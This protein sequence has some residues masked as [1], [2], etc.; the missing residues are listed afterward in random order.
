LLLLLGTIALL[1]KNRLSN[2]RSNT[3]AP[4]TQGAPHPTPAITAIVKEFNDHAIVAIGESH[5][6]EEAGDFYRDLVRSRL[7]TNRV[8]TVVVEFG[9]S[10]YQPLL[11]GYLSGG[12]VA[13]A[14]L[15]RVWQDTTQ[16]GSWDAPMYAAFFATV[17]KT[18]AKLA[19]S[20]RLRVL[21]GDPP[22]DWARVHTK[23]QWQALARKR[24]IFFA[25]VIEHEVLA[26]GKRALVIA[27]LAHVTHGGGGV[28]DL[29]EAR[30]PNTM[31]VAAV[32]DGFPSE[33]LERRLASWPVPS[34]A[35]LRDTWIGRLPLGG[36]RA[37]DS[38]DGLLYLGSPAS[39]HLSVTLP[40]VYRNDRYWLALHVRYEIVQG[41]PFSETQ[42]FATYLSPPYPSRFDPR[43]VRNAQRFTECMRTS[44]VE[45]FPYPEAQFDA[46]GFFGKA[47]H[48]AQKDPDFKTAQRVCARRIFKLPPPGGS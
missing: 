45:K 20:R 2:H 28:S 27:G 25:N 42:L 1:T 40:S 46:F 13:P 7:F 22:I 12:N 30:H 44:G 8:H 23:S 33:T 37:Q 6:L 4:A 36:R 9:N 39:L 41:R 17:R 24:E 3:K 11:D 47:A 19:P 35:E 5:D 38:L 29:V 34:L 21:L 16:V 32:H 10:R 26:K 18:N 31:F 48:E 14:L 15:R 43:D